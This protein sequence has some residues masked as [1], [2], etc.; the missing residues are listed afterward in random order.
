MKTRF[1]KFAKA[2]GI[3]FFGVNWLLA[4][5]NMTIFDLLA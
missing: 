4:F 3:A 5:G 2:V 1:I